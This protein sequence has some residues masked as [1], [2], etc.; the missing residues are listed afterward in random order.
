MIETLTTANGNPIILPTP[1]GTRALAFSVETNFERMARR[2][3]GPSRQQ[4]LRN[5]RQAVRRFLAGRP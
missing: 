4:A 5:A 2:P 1:Q 3:G